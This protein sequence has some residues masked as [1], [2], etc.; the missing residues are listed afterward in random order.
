LRF[1]SNMLTHWKMAVTLW[2]YLKVPSE[3]PTTSEVKP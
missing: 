1:C 3:V 2:V